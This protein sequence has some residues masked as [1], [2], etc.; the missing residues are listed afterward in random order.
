VLPA[1]ERAM[2]SGLPAVINIRVEGLA[3][4]NIGK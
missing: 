4:P 2:N 1:V 3:A